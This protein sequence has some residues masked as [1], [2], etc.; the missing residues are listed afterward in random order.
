MVVASERTDG[1][2]HLPDNLVRSQ[3]LQFVAAPP[4]T[5]AAISFI[6]LPSWEELLGD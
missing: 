2:H 3:F 6:L 5:I 1:V 4:S